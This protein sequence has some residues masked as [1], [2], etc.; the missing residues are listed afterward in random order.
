MNSTCTVNLKNTLDI[1][2]ELHWIDAN[3]FKLGTKLGAKDCTAEEV[4]ASLHRFF[5][6]N[7]IGNRLAGARNSLRDEIIS[8]SGVASDD[9]FEYLE[10]KLEESPP[11]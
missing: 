8:G 10:K 9:I 1:L 4:A 7:D 5:V 6:A 3:L 11:R 2:A